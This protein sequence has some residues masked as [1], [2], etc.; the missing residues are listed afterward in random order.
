MVSNKYEL[1]S[2]PFCGGKAQFNHDDLNWYW[3]E[4]ERCGIATVKRVSAMEDCKLLLA[5]I[6][7]HRDSQN[8]NR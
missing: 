5:E 3:I 6:W 8:K 4:C 7:N 2:C 1:L